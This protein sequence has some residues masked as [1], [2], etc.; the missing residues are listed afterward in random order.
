MSNEE[1]SEVFKIADTV[2]LPYKKSYYAQSG[3][4]NLS[5]GY[6]KPLVVTNV[7]GIGEAVTNYNLGTV[8]EPENTDA[9]RNGIIKLFEDHSDVYGFKRYKEENSWDRVAEKYIKIYEGL[10]CSKRF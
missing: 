1:A 10:L 6:E 5:I 7:G 8:V 9:M 2:I 3:V 4:L